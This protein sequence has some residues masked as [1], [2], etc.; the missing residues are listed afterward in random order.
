MLLICGSKDPQERVDVCEMVVH[1]LESVGLIIELRKSVT[2]AMNNT[3]DLRERKHKVEDLRK[4]KEKHCLCEMTKNAHHRES[5]ACE[6][7]E[8]VTDKDL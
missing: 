2:G 1:T 5:H 4:E 8:S 6:V 3:E 7:T